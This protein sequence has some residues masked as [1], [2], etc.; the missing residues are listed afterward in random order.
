MEDIGPSTSRKRPASRQENT[1]PS[2]IPRKATSAEIDRRVSEYFGY[3]NSADFGIRLGHLFLFLVDGLDLDDYE[4]GESE[5]L[6]K[7]FRML[8]LCLPPDQYEY[9]AFIEP[10]IM[11]QMPEEILLNPRPGHLG[12]EP[13]LFK[14]IVDIFLIDKKE[15]M[16]AEFIDGV[17]EE[18]RE[19]A[20]EA[21]RTLSRAPVRRRSP[22]VQYPVDRRELESDYVAERVE[23]VGKIFQDDRVKKD[24]IDI[25]S[26]IPIDEPIYPSGSFCAPSG[27]GKT[28]FAQHLCC[29]EYPAIYGLFNFM[30]GDTRPPVEYRPFLGISRLLKSTAAADIDYIR[31]LKLTIRNDLDTYI[32]QIADDINQESAPGSATESR[33]SGDDNTFWQHFLNSEFLSAK[34]GDPRLKLKFVGCVVELFSDLFRLKLEFPNKAWLELQCSISSTSFEAMTISQGRDAIMKLRSLREYDPLMLFLDECSL[35][36]GPFI[37]NADDLRKRFKLVRNICRCLGVVVVFSGT[38]ARASNLISAKGS[39]VRRNVHSFIFTTMPSYDKQLLKDRCKILESRF[40]GRARLLSIVK[41][42]QNIPALELQILGLKCWN[43]WRTCNWSMK[44][45]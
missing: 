32:A 13:V 34:A 20:E 39:V 25:V 6:L 26:S 35:R 38:D 31:S 42:M 27:S 16:S 30:E 9:A 43:K 12:P 4:G 28:T 41:F 44:I 5:R 18:W 2:K 33:F 21:I 37:S 15:P 45:P 19:F 36:R 7:V 29:E 10:L 11:G 22:L 3:E 14:R 40:S 23:F 17:F 24:F 1:L 8:I